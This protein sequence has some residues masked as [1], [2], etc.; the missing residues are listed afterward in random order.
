MFATVTQHDKLYEPPDVSCL[1]SVI[2]R[3]KAVAG[4]ALREFIL[5]TTMW[6]VQEV[7]IESEDEEIQGQTSSN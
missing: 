7:E 6:M 3:R 5:S 2:N 4:F 1:Y